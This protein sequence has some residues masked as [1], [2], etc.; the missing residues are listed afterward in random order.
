MRSAIGE[1]ECGHPKRRQSRS[2]HRC[3]YLDGKYPMQAVVI[4]TLAGTDGLS[5]YELCVE[6]CGYYT[7]DRSTTIGRVVERLFKQRRLR[8][9]ARETDAVRLTKTQS[10]GTGGGGLA[11]VYALDGMTEREWR[12]AG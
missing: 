10:W 11:W 8:R 3:A 12:R 9:Y 6:I 4:R 5:L 7:R 1:C 2:C